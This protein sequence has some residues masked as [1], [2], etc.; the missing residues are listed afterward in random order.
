MLD[1]YKNI[2]GDP[3]LLI[4]LLEKK[5]NDLIHENV[6]LRNENKNL[7]ITL[8]SGKVF[9]WEYNL[10]TGEVNINPN[11]IQNLGYTSD[12]INEFDDQ[13]KFLVYP[14]D[15]SKLIKAIEKLIAGNDNYISIDYRIKDKNEKTVWISDTISVFE[16][17]DYLE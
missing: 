10:I 5:V 13:L 12:E 2:N 4:R 6:L 15:Y 7:K 11:L 3:D 9:W 14:E 1:D 16:R 8:N 17:D